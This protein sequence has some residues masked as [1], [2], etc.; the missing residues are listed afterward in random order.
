MEQ[1]T[2]L[3]AMY[4]RWTEDIDYPAWCDYLFTLMSQVGGDE[5]CG[6]I[7]NILELG[8]GSGNMTQQLL[9]RGYEVVGIDCSFEMLEMAREKMANYGER[10]ILIEQDI[11]EMDF[12]IYE[13]DCVL[14][15]NDTF[16]YI[17]EEEELGEIFDFV[18]KHLKKG[19]YFVFDISSPYKLSKVLGDNTFGES[20]EDSCYLWENYYDEEERLL[21]MDINIFVKEKER[22]YQRMIET[23]YQRAHDP[24]GLYHL[25]LKA[26]FSRVG[27]FADYERQECSEK[28][29]NGKERIF[30]VCLK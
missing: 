4:D 21:T 16:N 22:L 19:G 9:D 15:A 18:W 24:M 27:L 28:N 3:P 13:I 7:Q 1:Y 17:L 11:R 20:F 14:S 6:S 2:Y 29:L 10:L 25:L 12:A 26:G 23:H 8:C 5:S 30:F